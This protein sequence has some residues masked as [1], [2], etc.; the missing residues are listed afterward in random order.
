[1]AHWFFSVIML[2]R[3]PDRPQN[4]FANEVLNVR[5]RRHTGAVPLEPPVLIRGE[6]GHNSFS[7]LAVFCHRDYEINPSA[8]QLSRK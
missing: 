2:R 1:M 3:L 8:A 6:F 7:G 5:P 4:Q